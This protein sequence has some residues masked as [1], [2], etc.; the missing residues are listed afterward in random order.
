MMV[1]DVSELYMVG[2]KEFKDNAIG[3]VYSKAPHFMM[4]GMQLFGSERGV[5]GITFEPLSLVSSFL[6]N[7]SW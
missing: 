2:V 3:L 1:A 6:L 4:L 7:R 5:K